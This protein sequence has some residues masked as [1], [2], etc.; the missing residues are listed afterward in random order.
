MVNFTYNKK[1]MGKALR[2][3]L[4]DDDEDDCFFFETALEEMEYSVELSTYRDSEIAISELSDSKAAI[5]DLLFLDWNMPK[6]TGK[7]CLGTIRE[8]P[9]LKQLPVIVYTTSKSPV[10]KASATEL[11]ASYFLT[12]PATFTELRKKL[13]QL[14]I[15]DWSV[16]AI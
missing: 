3:W 8:C 2:V 14:F 6:L 16:G 7:D 11:G 1:I 10:D 13:Q 5:P 15:L 4:I 9:H 12:K